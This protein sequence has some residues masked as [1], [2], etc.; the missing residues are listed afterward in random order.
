MKQTVGKVQG[1]VQGISTGPA[2]DEVV[3]NCLADYAAEHF[4]IACYTSLIAACNELGESQIASVCDQIRS[5]EE[6]MAQRL[7]QAIPV[8][9]TTYMVQKGH[10]KAA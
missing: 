6:A 8:V 3:K 9:T 4:E 10:E 7:M 5:Q 2:G 1:M